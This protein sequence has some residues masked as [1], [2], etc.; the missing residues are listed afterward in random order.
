MDLEP[1]PV[2]V[3]LAELGGVARRRQLVEACGRLAVDHA[4][5]AGELVRLVRGT[6]ASAEV[7]AARSAAASVSGVVSHRSAALLHGWAVRTTPDLPD[8]TISRNRRRP[9]ARH[10]TLHVADLGPD[11]V[12]DGVT[13]KDRTL[14]DCLRHLP[15]EEALAVADSALRAGHRRPR[16]LA[17]ARDARGPGAPRVR[18]V[19]QEATALAANPF[20]SS[21]RAIC[22]D[23][24]RLRVRAQVV[25]RDPHRLGRP[26]LV[27]EDLKIVLE[28]DSFEWHGDR[29]ALHRDANRYN[30]FVAAGWV[31][32][33]FSW[34]QVMFHPDDI[35]SVIEAV[36]ARQAQVGC[37]RCRAA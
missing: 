14:V 8:V 1:P 23:V 35:R 6:Y 33:R 3:A 5:A 24:P 10:L 27:D 13:S 20:E 2:A 7:D 19:A 16:L 34:E 4:L 12:E 17:L 36:V 9:A 28:A 21:L 22:L 15:L 30:G 25:V 32:L 26:D 37:T 31:V 11:D 29:A 18:R